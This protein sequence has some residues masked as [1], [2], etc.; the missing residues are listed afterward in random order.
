M[1]IEIRWKTISMADFRSQGKV[2]GKQKA[3]N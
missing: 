1:S 3:N 2:I